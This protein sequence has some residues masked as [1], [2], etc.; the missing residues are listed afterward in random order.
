MT[1]PVFL[2][3]VASLAI[4][5][6]SGCDKPQ[7]A[8]FGNRVRTY[9][10]AHPEVLEEMVQKLDE[11]KKL[12]AAS[13]AKAAIDAN[14][15][16]LERD[17]RDF[18][19]NPAG[20]ITVVEFYD[21]YCGYCKLAA[22]EMLAMISENPDIRFVF[23]ELPVV[24][25]QSAAPARIVLSA[26]AKG[27]TLELHRKFMAAKGLDADGIDRILRS[28]GIDPA[29]ARNGGNSDAVTQHISDTVALS[30]KIGVGGTPA[31]VVGNRLIEGGDIPAIRAAIAEARSGPMKS[32]N[33]VQVAR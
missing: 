23:K 21:Y 10:L 13:T 6:L 8:A 15:Q 5:A 16:A 17:P 24:T 30:H 12:Q 1:R 18:V 28:A 20:K 29:A 19:A 11:K 2:A 26:A 27:K 14:R 32:I 25:S 31:F 33:S 7:D 4:A 9:L 22:P 3:L